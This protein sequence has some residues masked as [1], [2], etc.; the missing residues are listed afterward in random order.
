[1][2][3]GSEGDFTFSE[4]RVVRTRV[5]R[6]SSSVFKRVENARVECA[7]RKGS[8]VRLK[9]R[10]E[11]AHGHPGKACKGDCGPVTKTKGKDLALI[12]GGNKKKV[13]VDP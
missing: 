9:L 4:V 7:L 3:N 2:E 8:A 11:L 6:G 5:R 12:S 10:A 1:M 13:E